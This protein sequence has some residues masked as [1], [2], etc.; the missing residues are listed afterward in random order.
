MNKYH[1]LLRAALGAGCL[2][3]GASSA[4]A[5]G[6]SGSVTLYGVVDVA[7]EHING[8]ATGGSVTRMS[9]VT[10][11]I[12]RRAGGFVAKRTLVVDCARYSCWSP[13]SPWRPAVFSKVPGCL[14]DR[15][16]SVCPARNGEA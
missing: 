10:G 15:P 6:Q 5:Q 12:S 1:M 7:V 4:W 3:A 16:M 2:W 13:A 14:A 11:G 9:S 8:S